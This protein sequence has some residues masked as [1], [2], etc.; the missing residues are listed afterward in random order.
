VDLYSLPVTGDERTPRV[1]S[2][3]WPLRLVTA[4][5]A[6]LVLPER[7][8]LARRLGRGGQADVWMAEDTLLKERVAIKVFHPDLSAGERERMRREVSLGRSLAHPNLV[9]VYELVDAGD[10]VAVVMEWVSEGSLAQRLETGPLPVDDVVRIADDTLAALSFLH[11]RNIVHRDVKPSNLLVDADGRIRLADLG[12]VRR[13]D[14]AGDLTRT[15]MTVG[16][17]MYMS[18]EQLRGERAGPAA[19]LYGLGVTLYQLLV[20]HAPFQAPSQFELARLHMQARVPDP[21]RARPDCPRWLGR[22]VARLLEK[23]PGD[24]FPDARAARGALLRQRVLWSPRFRRRLAAAGTVIAVGAALA[25]AAAR[26]VVPAI[27]RGETVRVEATTREIRGVDG[28]GRVTW[29]LA[30]DLP[31][32]EV[33]RV[34]V[35]GDGA[36]ETI[37]QTQVASLGRRGA[38]R[39][40]EIVI[41]SNTGRMVSRIRPDD[42]ARTFWSYDFPINLNAYVQVA[43]LDGDGRSEVIANCRHTAFFP[44]F[45][46]IYWSSADLWQPILMHSGALYD[47]EPVAGASPPRLRIAGINNRLSM[48]PVVGELVVRKPAG[49]VKQTSDRPRALTSG[50]VGIGPANGLEWA[51]YTPLD[52]GGGATELGSGPDGSITV[53]AGTRVVPLDRFGNPSPGANAGRDLRGLRLEF[54]NHLDRLSDR[55][56]PM[57]RDEVARRLLAA[58]AG[59]A[60]LLA[61][62]PYR[63]ILG[64]AA[65]RAFA[66]VLATSDAER[67]LR[68]TFVAAPYEDVAY[69]LAHIEAVAGKLDTAVET[70]RAGVDTPVTPRAAYDSIHLLLRLA[71]EQRD[72]QAVRLLLGKLNWWG[73]LDR[74]D[75]LGLSATLWSRAHVWWDR[76]DEGDFSVR[77]FS[78]APDGEALACLSRWRLGRTAADDPEAMERAI[79]ENP[80]AAWEGRLAQAAAYL[81]LG[82]DV[83]ALGTVGALI[84]SLETVSRDDFMNRQVLDLARGLY[85][86][87]LWQSGNR[88]QAVSEARAVRP[89][90]RDGLLPAILVDE[91]LA[92]TG[93]R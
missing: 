44:T 45:V 1:E 25:A 74:R 27:R 38:G 5:E 79:E 49:P 52:E 68:A 9:R 67:V 3:T 58:E 69:R 36:A 42:V 23:L 51:W 4:E 50:D 26:Y 62:P 63:A 72:E 71:I 14:D 21:R 56:Q 29:A 2:R 8:K 87:A 91:V 65:S 76:I 75:Q 30:T 32:R 77:S 70:L 43:D 60:A 46:M 55:N 35:D 17:P 61:E 37:A 20:G 33:V 83:E 12:L 92:G 19:D 34:D 22:F 28:H 80:D 24:R 18:P 93:R 90:L 57:D 10:R 85:V 41:V 11:E 31:I 47:L 39:H 15:A 86:K 81:G 64:L 73:T 54:F 82:R 13:M 88:A 84:A 16:T 7:W 6:G 78:F 66:R 59:A 53:R 40:S 48:L 89:M